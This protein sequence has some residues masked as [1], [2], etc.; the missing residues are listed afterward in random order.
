MSPSTS[1]LIIVDAVSLL[2]SWV[3]SPI[4]SSPL[5]IDTS[6]VAIVAAAAEEVWCS[7]RLSVRSQVTVWIDVTFRQEDSVLSDSRRRDGTG[8][9][10]GSSTSTI[11]LFRPTLLE[12]GRFD[13]LGVPCVLTGSSCKNRRGVIVSA[14]E[15]NGPALAARRILDKCDGVEI[16]IRLRIEWLYVL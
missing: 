15:A 8:A 16:R 14:I 13:A 5:S 2:V 7:W 4:I 6:R 12:A 9:A 11:C 3:L 1:E 10:A